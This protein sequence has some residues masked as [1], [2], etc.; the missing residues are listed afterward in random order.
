MYPRPSTI[1]LRL[2]PAQADLLQWELLG[3]LEHYREHQPAR[4]EAHDEAGLLDAVRQLET[5]LARAQ[6]VADTQLAHLRAALRRPVE[7]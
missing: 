6:A 4:L 7:A 5:G 1:L 2:T 3:L